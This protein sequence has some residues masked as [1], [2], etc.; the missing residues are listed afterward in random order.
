MLGTQSVQVVRNFTTWA[1]WRLAI[2]FSTRDGTSRIG[3]G[4]VV[5]WTGFG[6]ART[7]TTLFH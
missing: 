3:A 2:I 5:V 7:E 1:S 4:A 6:S